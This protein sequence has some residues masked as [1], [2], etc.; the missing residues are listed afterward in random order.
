[1]DSEVNKICNCNARPRIGI[2]I[3]SSP[4][5]WDELPVNASPSCDNGGSRMS[6]ERFLAWVRL[7]RRRL[8]ARAR[9]L[10][11]LLAALRIMWP[12]TLA[13]TGV[14]FCFVAPGLVAEQISEA[15][16]EYI[17]VRNVVHIVWGRY[18]LTLYVTI[19]LGA[20]L[21]WSANRLLDTGASALAPTPR[22]SLIRVTGSIPTL[23]VAFGFFSLQGDL[24]V[25]K[26]PYALMAAGLILAR[27]IYERFGAL[28]R[29]SFGGEAPSPNQL[30]SPFRRAILWVLPIVVLA[31]VILLESDK[32]LL[33]RY[34]AVVLAQV[35]GPINIIILSFAAWTAALSSVILLSKRTRIPII[36]AC[37]ILIVANN[38]LD[39]N[40]NHPIRRVERTEP[41]NPILIEN[42]F[43]DWLATRP[44]RKEF[45]EYPIIIISAEGGGIRA[46]FFTA[47]VLARIADR[48]PRAANHIFAISGVS[49][50]ALG[51]A[52]YAAA[53]KARPPNTVERRCDLQK[54]TSRFYE[55]AFYKILT[56]DHL[57]PLLIRMFSTD[58]LQ[59]L[60]PFPVNA[61]D[62]QLGLESS[63]ERS[64]R[65][66]FDSSVFL[67]SI[68]Q[69]RPTEKTPAVP[70]LFINVTRVENGHRVIISPIY[71]ESEQAEGGIDD[72]HAI[73]YWEAPSVVG[74][75]GASARFPIISPPG[76]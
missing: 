7:T 35:L 46:A 59:Q 72:W 44:D 45:A 74:A 75:A 20:I 67:E 2:L 68:Y 54:D 73:D 30:T 39:L 31:S 76:Y 9:P 6:S 55:D 56:D 58:A 41:A 50:G 62:R 37:V 49:G 65:R 32:T 16:L 26:Y 14:I 12:V 61:F 57:S 66:I 18:L 69:L 71:N 43:S 8:D 21:E 5:H 22:R 3:T 34:G 24:P 23:A 70:Y 4:A 17:T 52:I 1:M 36:T 53:M 63:L 48:C 27:L 11:E 42:A 19:T 28:A 13:L 60:L 51:A 33:L 10:I 15:M 40:D 29:L 64:F 38:V 25:Q 47:I